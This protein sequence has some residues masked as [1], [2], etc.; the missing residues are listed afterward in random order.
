[1]RRPNKARADF[2]DFLTA[3]EN[4]FSEKF[5]EWDLPIHD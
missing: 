5:R 4:F 2:E 1:M 3:R